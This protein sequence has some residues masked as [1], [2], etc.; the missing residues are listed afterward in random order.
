M[1]PY[2]ARHYHHDDERVANDADDR[3]ECE[4]DGSRDCPEYRLTIRWPTGDNLPPIHTTLFAR[5]VNWGCSVV[6]T[7]LFSSSNSQHSYFHHTIHLLTL[8]KT[9]TTVFE[10]KCGVNWGK[11]VTCVPPYD[12][13]V[14]I[15]QST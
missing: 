5:V 1:S 9:E 15:V 13:T 10:K 3:D 2:P 6:H 7:T 11:I 14:V 8:Y 4:Y 12:H